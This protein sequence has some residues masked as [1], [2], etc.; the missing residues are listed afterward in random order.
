MIQSIDLVDEI[1]SPFASNSDVAG[2][3]NHVCR[4]ISFCEELFGPD[5]DERHKITIAACFHDLGI[6][7]ANTFDY[8]PPSIDLARAY[9]RQ[10][11]RV[12]WLEEIEL[13]IDQH[14]RLRPI[15]ESKLADVFR[16]ADLVDFSLG[17]FKQGISRA[18]VREIKTEFP[19]A[20]FHRNL[21]R[22]AGRWICRHPLNA[23][24]VLKW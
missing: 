10:T 17:L 14:H 22:V 1:L 15:P 13:M 19:N 4:V 18:T 23:V 7:T 3:K 9:L 6:Y 8:L 5:E 11:G 12:D 21:A 16:K 2:Y 24:P 20:G